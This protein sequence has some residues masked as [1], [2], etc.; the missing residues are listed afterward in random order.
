L[1]LASFYAMTQFNPPIIGITTYGR[2]QTGQFCLMGTHVDAVRLAGGIAILL[3]P[4]ESNLAAILELVDGLV[5]SGG[6]DIDPATYKG[7]PHPEIY[8]VDPERDS[9]E[10]GLARAA[11]KAGTPMLGICRG[12]EILI[13]ASGG[14][15][16]PHLPDTYGTTV[17]HRADLSHPI[18]HSVDVDPKSKLATI[19]GETKPIVVSWHH[20]AV[21][22][23]TPEW[24]VTA[25]AADGVI[26]ALEHQHHPWAI[27][28]QWHPELSLNH[29]VQQSIFQ[30]LVA[31]ASNQRTAML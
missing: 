30:A 15:L 9:F 19:L 4:G 28:L 11:L 12:L 13:V 2:Q 8:L 10:L 27:A 23:I 17:T 26:E 29:P 25:S 14:T 24:K 7:S 21:G 3:P 6:G 22:T 20:Q 5:F 31:V 1:G 16:I 18:E